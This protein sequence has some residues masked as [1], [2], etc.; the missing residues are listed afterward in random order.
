VWGV[1][2]GVWGVGC[3]VRAWGCVNEVAEHKETPGAQEHTV[4]EGMGVCGAQR[5]VWGVGFSVAQ[6][7][8]WGVGFSVE[9][10]GHTV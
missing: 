8:V 3:G 2:C 9:C 10:L 7:R 5:R 6:R 1:G 4:L